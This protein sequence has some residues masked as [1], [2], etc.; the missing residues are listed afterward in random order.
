MGTP[1]LEQSIDYLS[2]DLD[3]V[4]G[5]LEGVKENLE[6]R[7]QTIR[8]EVH[9]LQK[10]FDDDQ[11]GHKDSDRRLNHLE[12]FKKGIT[13]RIDGVSVRIDG[14][15]ARLGH[16]RP[17]TKACNT[18]QSSVPS[19]ESFIKEAITRLEQDVKSFK[20]DR[21]AQPSPT[22]LP[23]KLEELDLLIKSVDI[24]LRMRIRLVNDLV[25]DVKDR[26]EKHL[27]DSG[28]RMI[29]ESVAF[30]CHCGLLSS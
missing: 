13:S 17:S 22:N 14:M 9:A 4:R 26:L 30:L 1:S 24:K 20:A 21:D 15:S 7:L 8:K 29:A 10:H 11:Y 19:S 3:E 6:D 27:S 25:E 23:D 2:I 18:P 28:K 12:D 5:E 16:S